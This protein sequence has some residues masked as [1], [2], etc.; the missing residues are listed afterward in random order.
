MAANWTKG[1]ILPLEGFGSPVVFQWNPYEMHLDKTNKWAALHP[2]GGERP[3]FHYGCGEARIISL[4]IEISQHNN[5]DFFVKGWMDKLHKLT[6]PLVKGSGI[7][8][9]PQVQVIIGGHLDCTA[10]IKR[11]HFRMG[12]HRGQQ[13]HFTYLAEPNM[14]LPRD[15][16]VIIRMHE[17]S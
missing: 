14:L 2:A 15:G 13:H 12:S 5:S 4:S 17:L 11:V 1:M 8:R 9:P 16:H 10:I 6:K 7:S 3:I